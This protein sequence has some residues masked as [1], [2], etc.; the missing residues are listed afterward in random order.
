VLFLS[1]H[2]ALALDKVRSTYLMKCGGCHG[3]EGHSEQTFI[4]VLRDQVGA[5]LCSAEGRAYVVRVPN[6]SMSLIRDD[7]LLAKVLNFVVFDLGGKSTPTGAAPYTAAEVHLLRQ[8]PL[9]N[10]DLESLRAGVIMRAVTACATA[11]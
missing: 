1:G 7:A 4:P 9:S 6:V 11:H 10:T 2:A 3:V 5:F 8:K